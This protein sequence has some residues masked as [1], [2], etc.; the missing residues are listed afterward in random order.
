[1]NCII[2]YKKIFII[3]LLII[4]S[5]VI[6]QL[7]DM[8]VMIILNCGRIIGTVFRKLYEISS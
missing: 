1:M 5:P 7:F 8:L 6:V 4:M 2:K 3:A